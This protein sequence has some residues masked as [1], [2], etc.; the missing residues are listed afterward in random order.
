M[1]AQAI[2]RNALDGCREALVAR[3]GEMLF[4]AQRISTEGGQVLAGDREALDMLN[5]TGGFGDLGRLLAQAQAPLRSLKL[6]VL[7]PDNEVDY[8]AADQRH[9]HLLVEVPGQRQDHLA[10]W[11]ED[12]HHQVQ[13]RHVA[14]CGDHHPL[15][16]IDPDAVVRRQLGDDGF[17][18]CIGT[19][20]GLI[21][22]QGRVPP[23][24]GHRLEHRR[25]GR[26]VHHPLAERQRA[27]MLAYRL[28]NHRDDRRL[29]R[30][31]TL[32]HGEGHAWR[33]VF[34]VNG[35]KS[36]LRSK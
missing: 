26:V 5:E 6:E 8:W 32:R 15:A 9:R 20:Y 19:V 22:V 14:A 28:R 1:L 12:R 11:I 29:H 34:S 21:P 33:Q 2:V 30:Q 4:R 13:E 17:D 3:A 36:V 27:R 7:S 31:R 10:A 23:E 16:G 35:L 24:R 18:Q 25:R